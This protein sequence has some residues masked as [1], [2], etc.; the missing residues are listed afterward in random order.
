VGREEFFFSRGKSICTEYSYKYTLGN[1]RALAEA[2]GFAVEHVW[3]DPRE[4]FSVH[5]LRVL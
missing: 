2:A 3:V 1:V 4:Y 5:Y